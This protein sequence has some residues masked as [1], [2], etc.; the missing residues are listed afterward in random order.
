MSEETVEKIWLGVLG[1][2][3]AVA[4]GWYMFSFIPDRDEKLFA[5]HECYV[6]LGCQTM[7]VPGKDADATEC[8]ASCTEEAK[9][10]WENAEK[11]VATK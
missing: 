5:I 7:G 10:Q 3:F 4:T 2:V 11:G 6:D 1:S 9:N 8:W